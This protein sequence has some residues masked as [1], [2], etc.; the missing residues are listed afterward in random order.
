MRDPRLAELTLLSDLDR[1]SGGKGLFANDSLPENQCYGMKGH[2]FK[3]LVL[4]LLYNELVNGLSQIQSE[5]NRLDEHLVY[6][7]DHE[8]GSLVRGGNVGL[9]INHKGRLRL[10]ALR[11]ELN[12]A[13]SVDDFG[14]LYRKQHW[15]PDW[16]VMLAFLEG[17]KPISV[18]AC[19]LDHFKKV[20]DCLGHVTADVVLKRYLQLLKE[21]IEAVGGEAYRFGGDEVVARIPRLDPV[22]AKNLGEGI[23]ASIER[24][25]GG[26]PEV[27]SLSMKPTTSVGVIT[28]TNRLKPAEAL[29]L[30]DKQLYK[31]KNVGRN[32]VCTD[33]LP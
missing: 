27:V 3:E 33:S 11:D 28:F 13:R 9:R 4:H 12:A 31:A 7:R 22:G 19:D 16:E 15:E 20:N 1:T 17:D 32:T 29:E 2:E 8:I 18:L 5:R 6:L 25:L 21:K 23:R 24:E 10:W 14:V 30:A 26:M